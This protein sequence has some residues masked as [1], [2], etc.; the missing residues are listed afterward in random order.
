MFFFFFT[1]FVAFENA[2]TRAREMA[3]V[4]IMRKRC[5]AESYSFDLK[6]WLVRLGS[7]LR[8]LGC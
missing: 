6:T 5:D 7:E 2:E 1:C 3:K 8:D 4:P